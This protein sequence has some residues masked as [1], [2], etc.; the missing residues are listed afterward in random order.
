[1]GET[2]RRIVGNDDCPAQSRSPPGPLRPVI[3]TRIL[4]EIG[5]FRKIMRMIGDQ[6][7]HRPG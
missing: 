2:G 1:M 6:H 5:K 7:E 3:K 4:A